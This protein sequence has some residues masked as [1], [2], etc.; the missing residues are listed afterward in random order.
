MA[1]YPSHRRPR[2]YERGGVS[3]VT[4]LLLAAVAGAVFLAI[5]WTPI[6]VVHY[7]VK[8]T[9]RD[10]MNRAIKDRDDA[11]LVEALCQKLRSLDTSEVIGADGRPERV[12][13][14]NLT[15]A[16][17]TWERDTTTPPGTLHVA[18]EYTRQVR[19]PY[20]DKVSEW[21]G[22]VDLYN[23]LTIPDWGPAR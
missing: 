19:Y 22:T 12:P 15:P 21:V 14:V 11:A 9:V 17:I 7:E 13:S 8:Q 20:V 18:F 10:Y 1:P 5:A 16:D 3:W 23:D 6:Y 4:L 2:R